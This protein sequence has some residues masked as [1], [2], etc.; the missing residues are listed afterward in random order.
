MNK[1]VRHRFFLQTL[2]IGGGDPKSKNS[3][4][5][6]LI[7][8]LDRSLSMNCRIDPSCRA[9]IKRG[10][11]E[12]SA[13]KRKIKLARLTPGDLGFTEDPTLD[14]I[15]KRANE[16]GLSPCLPETGVWFRYWCGQAGETAY[17]FASV[18]IERNDGHYFLFCATYASSQLWLRSYNCDQRDTRHSLHM[19]FIFLIPEDVAHK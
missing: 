7:K 8:R 15:F 14:E 11:F 13:K 4:V 6:Q 3:L 9:D 18:P 16:I 12:V 2:T 5:H 19:Y 10:A 17:I 1:S